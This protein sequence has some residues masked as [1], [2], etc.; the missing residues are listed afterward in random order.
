MALTRV[1]ATGKVTAS[2]ITF[3]TLPTVGNALIVPLLTWGGS[4]PSISDNQ[5]NV[6][7]HATIVT[8]SNPRLQIFWCPRVATS[9]GTFT[10]TFNGGGYY[11]ACAIEIGGLGSGYLDRDTWI[12]NTGTSTTPATGSTAALT[13][14]EVFLLAAYTINTG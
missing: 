2:T 6:Y 5:G 4:L 1:Q 3:S 11:V 14:D 12:T 7:L 13:A 8:N 10:I 9:A